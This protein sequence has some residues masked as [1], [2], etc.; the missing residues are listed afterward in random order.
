MLK[1]LFAKSLHLQSSYGTGGP[2]GRVNDYELSG[3]RRGDRS[4]VGYVRDVDSDP[5]YDMQNFAGR[6]STDQS[7]ST[8][9]KGGISDDGSETFILQDSPETRGVMMKTEITVT[10]TPR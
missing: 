8:V 3:A 10:Q 2:S 7:R 9:V 4:N 5:D 6:V 1:P